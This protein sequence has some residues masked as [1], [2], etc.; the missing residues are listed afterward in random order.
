MNASALPIGL[1]YTD[2]TMTIILENHPIPETGIL[3]VRVDVEIKISA[4]EALH[5]AQGFIINNLSYMCMSHGDPR[6]VIGERVCWQVD[7]H[8]TLPKLGSIGK[9]GE[10]EVDALTGDILL[11]SQEKLDK[12]RQNAEALAARYPLNPSPAS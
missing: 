5:K 1:C 10:I 11:V 6:L 7:I 4:I 8:H 3:N 9:I 2:F 12:M